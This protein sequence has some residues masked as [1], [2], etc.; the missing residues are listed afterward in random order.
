MHL[1]LTLPDPSAGVSGSLDSYCSVKP[2]CSGMGEVVPARTSPTLL[3]PSPCTVLSL[4]RF[5]VSQC[6]SYR[7]WT[8][9]EPTDFGPNKWD[10]KIILLNSPVALLAFFS[11][12]LFSFPKTCSQELMYTS[13]HCLPILLS[14]QS[15]FT[16][17]KSH[18][19]PANH[20]NW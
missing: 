1:T 16:G 14:I 9:S 10:R 2:L 3:P 17:Q 15:L 7:D 20:V 11:I 6:I 4:S 13:M 18:Y 12:I 8:N 19:P 5:K